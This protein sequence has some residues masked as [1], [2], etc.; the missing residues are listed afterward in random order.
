[1]AVASCLCVWLVALARAVTLENVDGTKVEGEIVQGR[2]EFL[3]IRVEGGRY[4]KIAWDKLSQATLKQLAD[5]SKLKLEA[6]I[7]PY[8]EVPE[9]LTIRKTEV[10]IKPVP[11]LER[12]ARGSLFGALF[13]SSVGLVMLLL[14]YV[15][16]IYAGYEIAAVRAYPAGM[17]CGI[18]AVVPVIGPA[19]FLF[20]PTRMKSA[21]DGEAAP[22]EPA[23]SLVANPLAQEESTPAAPAAGGGLSL[24]AASAGPSSGAAAQPQVYKRGQFT[25]NRRFI[26]TKFSGFFGVVRHGPEKEQALFIKSA[27]GEV[28]ATRISRITANDMHVE[29]HKGVASQEIQIPFGEI[30]EIQVKHKDA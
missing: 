18:A 16:N 6:F 21:A 30:L 24:A 8:L 28:V 4:E 7:Q 5:D 26:E 22:A 12:A 23:P 13:S 10:V 19:I 9:D 15:A 11:R 25:F 27:R 14:L 2:P 1:M 20:L 3:Q 29:A 17:V